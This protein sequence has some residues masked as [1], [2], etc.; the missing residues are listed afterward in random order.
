MVSSSQLNQLGKVPPGSAEDCE[1]CYPELLAEI[2]ARQDAIVNGPPKATYTDH[3]RPD[4]NGFYRPI[5]MG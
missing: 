3:D 5:E 1:Y 2:Q 4:D